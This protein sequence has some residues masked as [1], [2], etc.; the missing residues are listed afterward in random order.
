MA[1]EFYSSWCCLL[2]TRC[3][4]MTVT[5]RCFK[6]NHVCLDSAGSSSLHRVESCN[7]KLITTECLLSTNTSHGN[8]TFLTNFLCS[9]TCCY[10][11]QMSTSVDSVLQMFF[12]ILKAEIN[13]FNL[14]PKVLIRCHFI[15]LIRQSCTLI[16][17]WRVLGNQSVSFLLIYAFGGEKKSLSERASGFK[18]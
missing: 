3:V 16:G 18:V 15:L 11:P 7:R 1:V 17:W 6:Q 4:L 12:F 10:P 9:E 2:N 13:I 5:P 14:N 8:I